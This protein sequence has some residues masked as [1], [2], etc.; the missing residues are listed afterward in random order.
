MLRKEPKR[1]LDE[2]LRLVYGVDCGAKIAI[3]TTK[4]DKFGGQLRPLVQ[5]IGGTC[6]FTTLDMELAEVA[7]F[8]ELD[9]LERML[10]GTN[11]SMEQ[12]PS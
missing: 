3:H 12:T 10:K 9:G 5:A 8:L 4:L 6:Y 2:E 1:L 11:P 7:K